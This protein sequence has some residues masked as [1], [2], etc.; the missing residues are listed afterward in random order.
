MKVREHIQRHKELHKSLDELIADFISHTGRLPSKTP[1][2][3]LMK[4][5]HHQTIKPTEIKK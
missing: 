5:S 4:W 3:E 2:T 1:L